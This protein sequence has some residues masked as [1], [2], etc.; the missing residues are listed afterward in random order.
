MRRERD[1]NDRRLVN[2]SLTGTG[3]E[4]I[5]GIFPQHVTAIVEEMSA[6]TN[7]EQQTLGSLCRKL[8]KKEKP[9][10]D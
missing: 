8:G 2:V 1:V 4:L 9:G 10:G 6:L 3:R 7:N 5:E